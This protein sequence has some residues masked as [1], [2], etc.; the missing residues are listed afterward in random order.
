LDQIV[1]PFL[2]P[3]RR[4]VPIIAGFDFSPI[5]LLIIVQILES[6]LLRLIVNLP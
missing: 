1:Q 5:I 3:I 4:L 2:N 6:V